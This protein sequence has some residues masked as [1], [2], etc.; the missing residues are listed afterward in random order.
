MSGEIQS[1]ASAKLAVSTAI[2]RASEATGAGFD[3]LMKTALRES[4]LDANAKA[5]TSSAAG[6]FQF[7]EQTWLGAVKTYGARHGLATAAADITQDPSGKF[8]IADPARRAEVLDLRFDAKAASALAGELTQE[9][10]RILE[11]RL[12][13]AA[14]AADL[15][16]AHFLGP[17]GAVKLL[18][19]A[20]TVKAAD[21]LPAAAKANAPVFYDGA[22]A[23][24]VGEVI[25]SFAASL[26]EKPAAS[27]AGA[28]AAL[29]AGASATPQQDAVRAMNSAPSA[30]QSSAPTAMPGR[31]SLLAM[32]ILQALDPTR[33]SGTERDNQR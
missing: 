2:Q 29:G 31:L 26:G 14:S 15:Y 30:R 22:R 20:A 21:I 27:N 9:N 32:S 3:Y 11:T 24:T 19:A 8:Q 10:A 23:K 7:I 12:G 1:A 17:A 6:L 28:T 18:N 25:A 33:L 4:S 13:R 5:V 16:A